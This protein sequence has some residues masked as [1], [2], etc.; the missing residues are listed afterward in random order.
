MSTYVA[1]T[2][3]EVDEPDIDAL[4][5]QITPSIH[6]MADWHFIDQILRDDWN[7]PMVTVLKFVVDLDSEVVDLRFK[8]TA[9]SDEADSE[10]EVDEASTNCPVIDLTRRD[11]EA[12]AA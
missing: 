10:A 1:S 4:V 3:S 5:A 2:T 8:A 7:Q 11:T 12:T 6:E 9:D